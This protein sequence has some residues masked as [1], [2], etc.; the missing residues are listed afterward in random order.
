MDAPEFARQVKLGYISRNP[1]RQHKHFCR[2]CNCE[3]PLAHTSSKGHKSRVGHNDSGS[4][5]PWPLCAL[6]LCIVKMVA[7]A[8]MYSCAQL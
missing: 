4:D 5:Q 6:F 7:H 8:R 3:A 1:D 2:L